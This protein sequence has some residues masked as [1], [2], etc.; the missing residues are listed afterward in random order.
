[1]RTEERRGGRRDIGGTQPAQRLDE[2]LLSCRSNALCNAVPRLCHVCERG[3]PAGA[4]AQQFGQHISLVLR[5][6]VPFRELERACHKCRCL[7]ARERDSES[8]LL[9]RI[10][11]RCAHAPHVTRVQA[12]VS[13]RCCRVHEF[14]EQ[15]AVDLAGPIQVRVDAPASDRADELVRAE[16]AERVHGEAAQ[17]RVVERLADRAVPPQ[18][19]QVL[20]E[21]R[22]YE[23]AERRPDAF[24]PYLAISLNN[25]SSRLSD[26]GRRE[27]ALAVR[28]EAS[29]LCST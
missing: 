27:E 3:G 5:A 19:R 12:V 20:R 11:R 1:M 9:L 16:H 4:P 21:G 24:G 28:Q 23:L 14:R 26:L 10:V 2:F 7:E 29:Q 22:A 8:V 17:S 18:P 15:L 6:Q 25:L 13:P